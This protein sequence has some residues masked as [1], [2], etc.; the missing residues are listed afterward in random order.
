MAERKYLDNNGLAYYDGKVKARFVAKEAGKGLSTN[1]YTDAEKAKVA[2]AQANVIETVKVNGSALT[3]D[4]NKAVDIAVPTKTSDITN[5]SNFAVD[6]NYV[7]TDNNYSDTEKAKVAAAQANVIETVKVNGTALTPDANKAVDVAVPTKTSDLTNDSTFQTQAEVN[8]AISTAIAGVTQFDYEV[9]ATL[10]ASGVKGTIYLVANSGTGSNIYDE[11]LWIS[12]A[13]EKIGTT[14]IDLSG[15]YT[16]TETDTLLAG[17][18]DAATTYTKTEVDTAL[19]GKADNA[20]TLAGYGITNAYTKTETDTLLDEK[21]DADDLV[22]ITNAEIDA[23][24]AA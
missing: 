9:V 14:E 13:W 20:T 15:Y 7:H 6:A 3:P 19:A 24:V 21:L 4:G 23:I 18:A 17:K 10:P 11:Y 8:T 12:N 5:D 22:A 1:D 2:A 16:K